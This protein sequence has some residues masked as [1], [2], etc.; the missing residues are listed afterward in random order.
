MNIA[1]L[2]RQQS[3]SARDILARLDQ[4][5]SQAHATRAAVEERVKRATTEITRQRTL[6]SERKKAL[7]IAAEKLSAAQLTL[8]EIERKRQEALDVLMYLQDEHKAVA[9]SLRESQ[10]AT[11]T[12]LGE[13]R[14]EQKG[15]QHDDAEISRL[16]EE[17]KIA[18]DGLHRALI[19][20]LDMHLDQQAAIL[21][22]IFTTQEQ[23][24]KAMREYEALKNA[25]HT[26]IEIGRLCD[27]RDEFKKLLENAMVPGV[28]ITL[29]SSLKAIEEKL[30]KRFPTA[31]Q[32]PDMVH[33]D[34]QIEEFLFYCDRDGKATCLL[35][36]SLAD[37]N[38]E[39][40]SEER[41]SMAMCFVWNM[42]R[43]LGIRTEDGDFKAIN[44]RL[45]FASRFELEDIASQGFSVKCGGV[46]V[47]RYVLAAVP[48]E[49][50]EALS[51]ED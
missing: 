25:R 51:R 29:Q 23:R 12:S 4:R 1:D 9:Q 44:N 6:E 7:G 36:I 41:T 17:Q 49:L 43:E 10:G 5:I 19:K 50:Q 15:I 2:L 34:S 16:R 26:D 24:S 31:L 47:I 8:D 20:A 39:G 37:W 21:Q 32:I 33:R 11:E 48:T 22:G 27:E 35:P 30:S 46:E 28:K 42:I 45:V 38:N 18:Q 40:S 14:K 3:L 13:I